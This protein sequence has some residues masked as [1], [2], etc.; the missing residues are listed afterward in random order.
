MR[1]RNRMADVVK[2]RCNIFQNYMKMVL[3]E[4]WRQKLYRKA[5]T[6]V[7]N[8]TKYRIAYLAIY[9]KM[10][11]IGIERYRVEDM[12]VSA[13][14]MI[15]I[16]CPEIVKVELP[17]QDAIRRLTDERNDKD[18]SGENEDE[19]ELYLLG[20]MW[21]YDLRFFVRTVNKYDMSISKTGGPEFVHKSLEKIDGLMEIMDDER[22]EL[23]HKNKKMDKDIES[24]L[25]SENRTQK[26]IQVQQYY[27]DQARVYN[28][29]N[30]DKE[31][32]IK[33]SDAGV[34]EAH[35]NAAILLYNSDISEF[36]HRLYLA[37]CALEGEKDG[38]IFGLVSNINHYLSERYEHILTE[39]MKE[40][41]DGMIEKGY[42]V[43][44]SDDGYVLFDGRFWCSQKPINVKKYMYFINEMIIKK[45]HKLSDDYMK[46]IE[47]YTK[48]GFPITRGDDGLY[49]WNG[50]AIQ[51]TLT[52]IDI[53]GRI[54]YSF[55]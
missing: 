40:I 5:E 41:V 4:D 2:L 8:K 37:Y 13:M 7:E 50:K 55:D 10:R 36:E 18:H 28:D 26:W 12:D 31:F 27:H 34:K 45:G 1:V 16:Y 3:P 29:S 19:E 49:L 11:E 52:K 6:H 22:I 30:I 46:D 9:S 14:S 53:N 42:P 54:G 48:N 24:I 23:V 38:D 21:L 17:V 43:S 44:I 51:E 32:I 33:A 25:N 35:L 39:R 15:S 47:K 20:L